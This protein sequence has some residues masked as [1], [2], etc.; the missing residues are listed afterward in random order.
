MEEKYEV[1]FIC[2]ANVGRSQMAEGFYNFYLESKN[3]ISAAGIQ[4]VSEKYN[5]R[6]HPDITE[7]MA[8]EGIDISNQ[9]IDFVTEEMVDLSEKVI[10]LVGEE[11]KGKLLEFLQNNPKVQYHDFKD[12]YKDGD[13]PEDRMN[14]FRNSRD[15]IND[16]I[17][18]NLLL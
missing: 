16:F 12:P 17:L 8:E 18:K 6:P 2:A 10:A 15:Q 9:S 11:K 13:D 7:V 5:G 14:K 4:R 3:A 1:L